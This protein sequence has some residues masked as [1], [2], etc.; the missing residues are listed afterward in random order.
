MMP[1]KRWSPPVKNFVQRAC[2]DFGLVRLH[3]SAYICLLD[4]VVRSNVTKDVMSGESMQEEVS[5]MICAPR[6]ASCSRTVR[7]NGVNPP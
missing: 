6:F 7:P 5:A 3:S 4:V 2:I 1:S